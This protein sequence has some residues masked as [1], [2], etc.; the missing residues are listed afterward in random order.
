[1]VNKEPNW[2]MRVDHVTA[3]VPEYLATQPCAEAMLNR[4]EASQL[5][6]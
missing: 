5:A 2:K 6:R 1:M 4:H 3:K